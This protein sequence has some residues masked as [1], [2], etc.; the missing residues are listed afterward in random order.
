MVPAHP[1]H[2]SFARAA[3]DVECD[4]VVERL[5]LGPTASSTWL[6]QSRIVQDVLGPAQS[7]FDMSELNVALGLA[8]GGTIWLARRPQRAEVRLR[9]D[10]IVLGLTFASREGGRPSAVCGS[11]SRKPHSVTAISSS[12]TTP[13]SYG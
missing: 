5:Q 6:N 4:N 7:T 1:S 10:G 2:A 8:E 3:E 9:V 13:S 11:H 12:A